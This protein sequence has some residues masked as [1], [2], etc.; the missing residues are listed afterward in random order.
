MFSVDRILPQP[1]PPS[2]LPAGFNLGE[3]NN[4]LT[5]P[6]DSSVLKQQE[7]AVSVLADGQKPWPE[8]LAALSEVATALQRTSPAVLGEEIAL[9]LFNTPSHVDLLAALAL[10]AEQLQAG[11]YENHNG[12]ACRTLAG[13]R[14]IGK[15]TVMRAFTYACKAAYPD[16]IPLYLTAAGLTEPRNCFQHGLL[17]DMMIAAARA[18]GVQVDEAASANPLTTA[19][20]K[21]GKRMLVIVDEIEELYRFADS[22]REKSVGTLSN[23][24]RLGDQVSGRYAVLICGSAAATYRLISAQPEHLME[25]FVP[26]LKSG[27]PDLN[28]TK[29]ARR[30][31]PSARCTHIA[32]V[33][34]IV[35]QLRASARGRELRGLADIDDKRLQDLSRVLTFYAGTTPRTVVDVMQPGP[36]G[37]LTADYLTALINKQLA[38]S[39]SGTL[40]LEANLLFDEL[41][42]LLVTANQSLVDRLRNKDG[43]CDTTQVILEPWEQELKSLPWTDVSAAWSSLAKSRDMLRAR[44]ES[45]LYTL[46]EALSDAGLISLR[47]DPGTDGLHVWPATV[48]QLVYYKKGTVS[49]ELLEGSARMLQP[50][51]GFF[52]RVQ[53][54]TEAA[55][56]AAN[57]AQVASGAPGPFLGA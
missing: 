33:H 43:G 32:Q 52:R 30:I 51:V 54:L 11:N 20:K 28:C 3:F 41:L 37:L 17:E 15:S 12:I 25:R 47:I 46:A 6:R 2:H 5:A 34:A 48:A 36:N 39:S 13:A 45:Y 35:L 29:F 19:L 53:P 26:L 57:I 22:R 50:L 4:V 7:R 1:L 21:A 23:L 24:Q 44:D 42:R 18:H 38:S 55:G 40:P 49:E 10:Q 14:G 16:I 8:R 27:V 9:P 31:I 56:V